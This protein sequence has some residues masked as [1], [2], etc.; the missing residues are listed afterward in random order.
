MRLTAAG[1]AGI[2]AL[3]YHRRLRRRADAHDLSQFFRTRRSND[4]GHAPFPTVPPCEHIGLHLAA[5]SDQSPRADDLFDRAENLP[6]ET[7][8]ICQ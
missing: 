4:G 1:E 3:R 7:V 6:F 5:V 2:A 8:A